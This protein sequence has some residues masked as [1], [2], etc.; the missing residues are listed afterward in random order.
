MRSAL[1]LVYTPCRLVDCLMDVLTKVEQSDPDGS[2]YSFRR[3]CAVGNLPKQCL[4]IDVHHLR[5]L[6]L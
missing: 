4:M 3:E 2:W 1:S 5:R 6:G